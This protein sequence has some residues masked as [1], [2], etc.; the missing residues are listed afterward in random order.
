M[1]EQDIVLDIYFLSIFF[2]G[3]KKIQ[4]YKNYTKRTLKFPA[5]LRSSARLKAQ[6]R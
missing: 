1:S 6:G 3:L 5:A 2:Q 4:G